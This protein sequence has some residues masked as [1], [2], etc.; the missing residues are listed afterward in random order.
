[1][2]EAT[3][4]LVAKLKKVAEELKEDAWIFEQPRSTLK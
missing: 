4:E 1:M 2:T 3:R